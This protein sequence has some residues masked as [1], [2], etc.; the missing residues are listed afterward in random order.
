MA[1][2]ISAKQAS[3]ISKNYKMCLPKETLNNIETEISNR[4]KEQALK[5]KCCVVYTLPDIIYTTPAS[6]ELLDILIEL[7]EAE[8]TLCGFTFTINKEYSQKHKT[9]IHTFYIRW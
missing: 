9:Y 5:Q 3:Q 6:P 1:M 8:L 4:I 7:L 2:T